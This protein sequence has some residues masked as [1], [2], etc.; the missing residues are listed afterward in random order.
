[1]LVYSHLLFYFIL[2][3]FKLVLLFKRPEFCHSVEV[4]LRLCVMFCISSW[5]FKACCPKAHFALI[6]Q[7]AWGKKE[8]KEPCLHIL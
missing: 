2:E 3:D 6:A 5:L 4:T 8:A 1:M 7:L